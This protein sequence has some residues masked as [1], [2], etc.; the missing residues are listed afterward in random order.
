MS[1]RNLNDTIP[2]GASAFQTLSMNVDD[3]CALEETIG[4]DEEGICESTYFTVDGFLNLIDKT[5]DLFE[6]SGQYELVAK[7][8]KV[9]SCS[10]ISF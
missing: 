3:E 6:K 5:A 7:I 2:N 8:Y 9:R 10:Q 1:L 4:P